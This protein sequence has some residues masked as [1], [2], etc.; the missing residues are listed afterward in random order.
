MEQNFTESSTVPDLPDTTALEKEESTSGLPAV[1]TV[2]LNSSYPGW[3]LII[4]VMI[5]IIC[6]LG[7]GGNLLTIIAFSKNRRLREPTKYLLLHLAVIDL[8]SSVIV[9]DISYYQQ[10]EDGI[11][12][13]MKN[14]SACLLPLWAVNMAIYTSLGGIV[15][16]SLERLY[17]VVRPVEHR[18]LKSTR[19][20]MKAILACLCLGGTNGE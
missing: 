3:K 18:R 2:T 16:V 1:D 19:N 9:I 7:I 10:I 8:F 13:A 14:K 20:V 4:F 17:S 11:I 12:T 6:I 5:C 15:L